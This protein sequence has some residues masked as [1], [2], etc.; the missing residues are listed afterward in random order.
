YT[1]SIV[2]ASDQVFGTKRAIM[3]G[4]SGNLYSVF[5]PVVPRGVNFCIVDRTGKILFH[6]E[7]RRNL[8][9]NLFEEVANNVALKTAVNRRDSIM[10]GLTLYQKDVNLL[11]TPLKG[12][13][14]YLVTY[15][16]KRD[17]ILHVFHILGFTLLT[18]SLLLLLIALVSLF[19]Y[20]SNNK[21]S[22]LFFVENDMEFTKPSELKEEY[23]KNL[24]VFHITILVLSIAMSLVFTG[25]EWLF[26]VL[27]LSIQLPLFSIIG[28]YLIRCLENN[29][30]AITASKK[31][32]TGGIS[33]LTVLFKKRKFRS[34]IIKVLLPY[35]FIVCLFQLNKDALFNTPHTTAI[36]WINAFIILLEVLMPVLAISIRIFGLPFLKHLPV[37]KINETSFQHFFIKALLLSAV[38][39]TI[40]PV[41]GLLLYA[42]NQEKMLQL[43]SRQ[44]YEAQKIQDRRTFVNATTG[45]TK[46]GTISAYSVEDS[47]FIHQL[48]FTSSH[49]L[50]VGNDSV[51]TSMVWRPKRDSSFADYGLY[52]AFTQFLFLPPDHPDF[53]T[54]KDYYYFWKDSSSN[55][56]SSFWNFHYRNTADYKDRSHL[57]IS[58]TFTV[59]P[60]TF[61]LFKNSSSLLLFFVVIVFVYIFY[62]ILFAVSK[63]IFLI[64]YFEHSPG[65]EQD[66]DYLD[67]KYFAGK[68]IT[69][70]FELAFW[71]QN[72]ITT[73]TILQKESEYENTEQKDE[74]ILKIQTLLAAEYENI[75]QELPPAERFAVYDIAIDSFTNY[76]N[77]DI[78]YSL[79]KKGI[80]RKKDHHLVVMNNSFRN[81]LATKSGSLEIARLREDISEGGNW[82][83]IRTVLL[84]ITMIV[85]VFLFVVQEDLSKRILAIATTLAALIPLMLKV[86]SK[87]NESGSPDKK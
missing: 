79:Y 11:V 29:C 49:G 43:K 47:A 85:V 39:T 63:R 45:N 2:K 37:R 48:K 56:D 15:S 26:F 32:T 5:N 76:K 52:R 80:L 87:N 64:G 31:V 17:Q 40:L 1:V 4:M 3:V 86:F 46:L 81:Y 21:F 42:G 58:S 20:Y 14:Y 82:G 54:N 78:I 60:T 24:F 69:D 67:K 41:I 18:E 28:Y 16:N 73:N 34:S 71:K 83:N 61:S 44:M 25:K 57:V 50:Y 6:S 62:Q 23:Y 36:I 55:G 77:I 38:M 65:K 35:I 22:Q 7:Y 9:E 66:Q 13:P 19:F 72:M 75:W 68:L 59:T 53:F 12:L 84:V 30:A 8:Q 70:P 33:L 74:C 10:L 27:N 51:Y